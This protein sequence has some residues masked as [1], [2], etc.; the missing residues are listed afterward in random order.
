MPHR[1]LSFLGTPRKEEVD[2][3]VQVE[4]EPIHPKTKQIVISQW[5]Q[6]AFF[7]YRYSSSH[8]LQLF[9][10]VQFTFS[11]ILSR[12][13]NLFLMAWKRSAKHSYSIKV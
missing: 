11:R 6:L 7:V 1:M 5:P 4:A 8:G 12:N 3:L 10:T 9:R 2:V 13:P